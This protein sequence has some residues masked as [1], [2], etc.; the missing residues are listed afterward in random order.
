MGRDRKTITP[1]RASRRKADQK[2][3]LR[4]IIRAKRGQNRAEAGD[5]LELTRAAIRAKLRDEEQKRLFD[6]LAHNDPGPEALALVVA[7]MMVQVHEERRL[8]KA[9]KAGK[10]TPAGI[11]DQLQEHR[12][13]T[14]H[15]KTSCDVIIRAV[16]TRDEIAVDALPHTL[17]IIGADNIWADIMEP[18]TDPV[19]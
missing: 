12:R 6:E 2:M 9:L 1:T 7:L 19:Q 15:L 3:A 5:P 10:G 8:M 14:R 4:D 13:S 11:K 17:E 16:K 18:T